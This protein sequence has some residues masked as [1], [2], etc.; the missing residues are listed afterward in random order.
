[1]R[2]HHYENE[3]I[4][5]K[6]FKKVC[7]FKC[8]TQEEELLADKVSLKRH[9]KQFCTSDQLKCKKCKVNLYKRFKDVILE[10]NCSLNHSC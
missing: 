4:R 5:A 1:M 2:R 7:P 9:V 8:E 10:A 6:D 3:C